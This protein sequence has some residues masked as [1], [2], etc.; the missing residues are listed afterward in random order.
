[1]PTNL[2][3]DKLKFKEVRTGVELKFVGWIDLMGASNMMMRSPDAVS[4][5]IGCLH[6]AVLLAAAANSDVPVNLHPL[7]DGVY[8]VADEYHAVA[9]VVSR[10]FRSYANKYFPMKSDARFCPIRASIAFGR[11]ADLVKTGEQLAKIFET[12]GNPVIPTGY[13]ENIVQGTA[14]SAAHEAERKAP[15]FGIYHDESLRAFGR[16]RKNDGFV[17]WPFLKW[18]FVERDAKGNS[19]EATEKQRVLAM[20]FGESLLAHFDWIERHP[21]ESGMDGD[22]ISEKIEKYR[23]LIREYFGV[24]EN[25]QCRTEKVTERKEK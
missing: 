23:K 18:W 2:P 7:A 25:K 19:K 16:T 5:S 14:F 22:R 13:L 8:V 17:T 15:P 12:N 10:T 21:V 24:F 6:E 3:F 11:V 20:Q 9:S 4:K 1:M